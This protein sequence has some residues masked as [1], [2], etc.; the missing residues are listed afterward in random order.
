MANCKSFGKS[1]DL[2][3]ERTNEMIIKIIEKHKSKRNRQ[4]NEEQREMSHTIKLLLVLFPLAWIRSFHFPSHYKINTTCVY[5]AL[6]K[7]T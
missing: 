5:A 6:D 1:E 2:K 7:R 4:K 3:T